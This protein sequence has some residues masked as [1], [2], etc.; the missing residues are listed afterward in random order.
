MKI[1]LPAWSYTALD[2]FESCPRRF[3]HRYILKEQE[4]ESEAQR[5]GKAVHKALEDRVK[6]TPLPECYVQYNPIAES[7]V[8]AYEKGMKVYT[9]MKMGLT[10]DMQP[11]GFFDKNVWGRAAADVILKNGTTCIVFDY[12]TG[13]RREKDLQMD[14]LALFISKHF[15]QVKKITGCNLWLEDNDIGTP[16][17][18]LTHQLEA[19]W[20]NILRRVQAMEKALASNAWPECPSGLC[21]FCPVRA[22]QYNR[23]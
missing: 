9:E 2:T 23:S 14:V 20:L 11:C 17:V 15:P 3:F 16:R 12:K 21:S 4:P 1:Q 18:Y 5:K 19:V 22:C 7:I 10:R 8:Q 6:G 13:K